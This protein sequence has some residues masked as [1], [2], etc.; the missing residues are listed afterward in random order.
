MLVAPFRPNPA[1]FKMTA[2]TQQANT[3]R[4]ADLGVEMETCSG[5]M[6]VAGASVPWTCWAETHVYNVAI[7]PAGWTPPPRPGL[8]WLPFRSEQD[9]LHLFHVKVRADAVEAAILKLEV[10][11]RLYEDLERI[12]GL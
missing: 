3:R 5:L 9:P 8:Q 10:D 6:W 1:W 12:E 2:A 4:G 7:G 11:G